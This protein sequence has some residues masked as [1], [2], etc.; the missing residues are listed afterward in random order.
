MKIYDITLTLSPDL[1][2]WPGDPKVEIEQV[3]FIPKGNSCNISHLAMSVHAGTHVDAPY[4]FLNDGKTVETLPLE[5]LVGP[6]YVIQAPDSVEKITAAVLAQAQIP[7]EAERILFKTR[8]SAFWER[9]KTFQKDFV[10]IAADGAEWL[11]ACNPRLIG[12]DYLSVAPFGEGTAT[13]QTLLRKGIVLLEGL[14]LSQV[15]PGRY[16]L[17]CLPLK[18]AKSDGAP[19]RVVLIDH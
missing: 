14:N 16:D 18:I 3:A 12:L 11:A 13:H 5:A 6:S 4:H 8:N 2:V 15:Q 7:A 9:E 1:P 10:A 19:A 17:Y